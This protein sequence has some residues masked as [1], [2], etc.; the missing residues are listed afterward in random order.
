VSLFEAYAYARREVARFYDDEGR[1]LTETAQLDDN[2]DGEGS[3]APAPGEGD[4]AVARALFL[5]DPAAAV[6]AAGGAA[7]DPGLRALYDEQRRLREQIEQLKQLK[8]SMAAELY[9][10][11]LEDLLVALARTD[12]QIREKGGQ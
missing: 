4:G 3:H 10:A 11:E 2:G 6:T 1:M 9:L 8:A 5:D 7:S 12:E